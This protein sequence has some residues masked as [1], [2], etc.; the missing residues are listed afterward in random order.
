MTTIQITKIVCLVTVG[1]L[2]VWD[3]FAAM[4]PAS[5]TTISCQ[6]LAWWRL[7]PTIIFAAGY[8]M[9]HFFS[10]QVVKISQT[11]KETYED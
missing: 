3:I 8:L 10:P 1:V 6:I 7:H 9:G 2:V 5:C 11:G 4:D